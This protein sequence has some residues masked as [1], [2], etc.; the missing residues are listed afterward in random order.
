MFDILE[1]IMEETN[2][3]EIFSVQSNCQEVLSQYCADGM[4]G[5][6]VKLSM[7]AHDITGE[8]F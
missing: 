4:T 1:K 5:T 7:I 6:V 3:N 2:S 8:I